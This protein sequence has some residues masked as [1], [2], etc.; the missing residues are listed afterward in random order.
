MEIIGDASNSIGTLFHAFLV[1]RSPRAASASIKS[2]RTVQAT[3]RSSLSARDW[4]TSFISDV[5]RAV[6][7][8]S[9]FIRKHCIHLD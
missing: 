5:I 3:V 2:L 8:T 7:M 9:F 1:L 6:I 4:M